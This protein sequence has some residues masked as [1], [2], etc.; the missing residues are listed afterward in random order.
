MFGDRRRL[1]VSIRKKENLST[2]CQPS[3]LDDAHH[4]N[5]VLRRLPR[6]IADAI[7]FC[8]SIGQRY[9]WVDSLCIV[10][11]DQGEKRRLIH[12][13]NSVYTNANLTLVSLGGFDADAGLAG[14]R[15]RGHDGDN[16][17]REHLYH[18]DHETCSIGI[19]RL[20]LTE[21]VQSSYWSTRGW[22]Y[23]EELLSP[24]KLYFAPGELFYECRCRKVR[25]GYAFENFSGVSARPG[26]PWYGRT[27]NTDSQKD[28][29]PENTLDV[30]PGPET[31]SLWIS[32]SRDVE[33]QKI[34]SVYTRRH[35]KET[36][37]IL[38]A[39]TGVY[40]RFYPDSVH[41]GI[42]INA[43]QGLP[44][45]SFS[46]ALLWFTPKPCRTKRS[47]VSTTNPSTWSWTSWVTPVDF[48]CSGSPNFPMTT[49]KVVHHET[50]AFS[51]VEERCLTFQKGDTVTKERFP[52]RKPWTRVVPF[53]YWAM[54]ATEFM[55][56]LPREDDDG[57]DVIRA[58]PIPGLLEFR[59]LYIPFPG[60]DLSPKWSQQHERQW[61]LSF[62]AI[63]VTDWVL[64]CIVT[65]LFDCDE[66]TL[67]GFVLLLYDY[68]FLG[69]CVRNAGE[70]F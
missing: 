40:N 37:D 6:T 62:E 69:I 25:E 13:M 45:G 30:W 48:A 52:G 46:R 21:Q 65:A 5:G 50:S 27:L 19:S 55:N 28:A 17:G 12:G 29:Q 61:N 41:H 2:L 70:Y 63:E 66:T 67:D 3:S 43:L 51:L 15:S 44:L 57:D 14:M 38:H 60:P 10:Q 32:Q 11:D 4:E 35:L 31:D 7:L 59:G 18:E 26:A 20:S 56:T 49:R 68:N 9:L 58:S 53:Q 42:G 22:T 1:W 8:R 47:D 36:D 33:F 16:C 23:Q 54:D 64:R 34:V 24:R 39:L